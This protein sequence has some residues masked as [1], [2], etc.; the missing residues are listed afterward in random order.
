MR[1][2][3]GCRYPPGGSRARGGRLDGVT[4]TWGMV[5]KA[6]GQT[7][8]RAGGREPGGAR[9]LPISASWL[10]PTAC[11]TAHPSAVCGASRTSVSQLCAPA[12][13]Q[14]TRRTAV[15]LATVP[16]HVTW[17]PECP[18]TGQQPQA[19]GCRLS[20]SQQ[21]GLGFTGP[22]A[23]PRQWDLRVVA[24]CSYRKQRGAGRA[25]GEALPGSG[26]HSGCW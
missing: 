22:G 26:H 23:A 1:G 4:L 5:P 3:W 12:W 7:W 8:D 13:P 2:P 9:P 21:E 15:S 11:R 10:L 19:S 25:Q 16:E 14:L 6:L 20:R 17:P 18:C 24:R